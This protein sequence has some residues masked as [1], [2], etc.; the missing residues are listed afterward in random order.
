MQT[1]DTS[2]EFFVKGLGN[3][4]TSDSYT[5]P[6]V[7]ESSQNLGPN[8]HGETLYSCPPVST[9]F[10]VNR[11]ESK[12]VASSDTQRLVTFN[13]TTLIEG[14]FTVTPDTEVMKC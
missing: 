7:A 4:Y 12:T 14:M 8:W 13:V 1:V 6:L 2:L 3:T 5:A 11:I 10:D 9:K